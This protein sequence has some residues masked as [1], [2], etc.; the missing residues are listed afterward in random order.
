M[1][2]GPSDVDYEDTLEALLMEIASRTR[3]T[4]ATWWVQDHE[5]RDAAITALV[6]MCQTLDEA[7]E[8]IVST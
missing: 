2:Y 4:S 3:I 6:E 5:R 7:G 1:L 8:R